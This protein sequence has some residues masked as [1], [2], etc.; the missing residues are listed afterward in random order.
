MTPEEKIK[1]C[2]NCTNSKMDMQRGRVCKL[3]DEKPDFEETCPNFVEETTT[4]SVD[5][6][7]GNYEFGGWLKFM[8]AMIA[9][10]MIFTVI[11]NLK[12]LKDIGG[13]PLSTGF[14][15]FNCLSFLG[16]GTYTIYSFL[17]RKA[18]SVFWGYTYLTASIIS[19]LFSI[20]GNL[21]DSDILIPGIRS[22][23]ACI[24]WSAFLYFS[25]NVRDI[26]PKEKRHTSKKEWTISI[27][28][29]AMPYVYLL[30]SVLISIATAVADSDYDKT[31]MYENYTADQ[32]YCTDGIVAFKIPSHYN[33]EEEVNDGTTIFTITDNPTESSETITIVSEVNYALTDEEFEEYFESW[34][35]EEFAYLSTTVVK[36]KEENLAGNHY[37]YRCVYFE[38]YQLYWE[39]AIVNSPEITKNCLVSIYTRQ[40][41]SRMY[42]FIRNLKFI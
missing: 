2:L 13:D 9:L 16:L 29:V 1:V 42:F 18:N 6:E 5:S 19:N 37:R 17:S 23:A 10:G 12:E 14:V 22:L 39:F 33:L 15:V 3:T 21:G 35:D 41:E 20:F 11:N 7:T 31:Y 26:F 28:G 4:K 30:F 24:A 32:G 40:P 27:L 25:E 38:D 36:D 8:L 34:K